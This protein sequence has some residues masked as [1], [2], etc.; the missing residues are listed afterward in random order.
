MSIRVLVL[1]FLLASSQEFRDASRGR[2]AIVIVRHFGWCDSSILTVLRALSFWQSTVRI[3]PASPDVERLR[4]RKSQRKRDKAHNNLRRREHESLRDFQ[5][6]VLDG[7]PEDVKE[8][9]QTQ[10]GGVE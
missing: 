5:Q 1:R 7:M 8:R 10:L 4:F 9:A 2:Q 3:A 6:R